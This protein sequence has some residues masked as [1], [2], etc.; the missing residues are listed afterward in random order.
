[1][2]TSALPCGSHHRPD[3]PVAPAD[4]LPRRKHISKQ[5]I[6]SRDL[7]RWWPKL[8]SGWR[9]PTYLSG[10]GGVV[11]APK[12]V[13]TQRSLLESGRPGWWRTPKR[14]TPN[15]WSS[16]V[17]PS[18]PWRWWRYRP[19]APGKMFSFL[20][21]S[22]AVVVA[23][24]FAFALVTFFYKMREGSIGAFWMIMESRYIYSIGIYYQWLASPSISGHVSPSVLLENKGNRKSIER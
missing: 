4:R 5:A 1:M 19:L 12:A 15:W 16:P 8:G 22:V 3:Y 13:G 2:T 11:E 23:I 21:N 6:G 24:A 18:W 10:G 14:M 9:Y 7:N 17:F 20:F